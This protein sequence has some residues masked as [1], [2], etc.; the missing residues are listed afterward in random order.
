MT[1]G[2]SD[3]DLLV[4]KALERKNAPD[5]RLKRQVEALLAQA[6]ADCTEDQLAHYAEDVSLALLDM[7]ERCKK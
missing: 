5:F 4:Q 2:M 7:I 1:D 6:I 3:E